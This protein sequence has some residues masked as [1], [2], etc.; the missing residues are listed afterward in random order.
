[1]LFGH[2]KSK[3]T[4]AL[5]AGKDSRATNPT[6]LNLSVT[7]YISNFNHIYLTHIV[8]DGRI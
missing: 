2:G 3:I 5:T 1:M 8:F 7:S 4:F 6:Y